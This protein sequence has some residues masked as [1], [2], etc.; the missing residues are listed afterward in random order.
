MPK[1]TT[2]TTNAIKAIAEKSGYTEKYLRQLHADGG[3]P[4][5]LEQAVAW[6]AARPLT[7]GT[8]DNSAAELRRERVRL[9]RA[10]AERAE[11]ELAVTRGEYISRAENEA[12]DAAIAIALKKMLGELADSLSKKLYGL[13]QMEMRGVIKSEVILVMTKFQDEKSE[14]W[15]D[16]PLHNK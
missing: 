15:K 12:S 13:N 14:Y 7:G 9:V 11:Q 1:P 4:L 6:L 2:K 10:Q 16:H 5:D 8:G 3:M